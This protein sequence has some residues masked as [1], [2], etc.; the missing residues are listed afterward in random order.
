MAAKQFTSAEWKAIRKA[1]AEYPE[2][3][4][5]PKRVYGSVTLA[6]FNIR[7][8]GSSRGRSQD[9]W[10]FLAYVCKHFGGSFTEPRVYAADKKQRT[11]KHDDSVLTFEDIYQRGV[12]EEPELISVTADDD[13]GQ[14]IKTWADLVADQPCRVWRQETGRPF[15]VTNPLTGEMITAEFEIFLPLNDTIYSSANKRLNFDEQARIVITSPQDLTL[16]VELCSLR[17]NRR[18]EHHAE[19]YCNRSLA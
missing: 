9:T 19:I 8:L 7:K 15:E 13:F 17:A 6:S 12:D 5:L 4:G 3:F 18:L 11:I 10:E 16:N 14:P 2:K 1:L